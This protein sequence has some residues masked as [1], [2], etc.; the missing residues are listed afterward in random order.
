MTCLTWHAWMVPPGPPEVLEG[1]YCQLSCQRVHR[2]FKYSQE[3]L[4]WAL[5]PP[6]YRGDWILG[7][8]V[9][10]SGKLV[11][12]ITGVPATV[13]CTRNCC[14]HSAGGLC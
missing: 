14:M 11:A 1:S 4:Q 9:S 12:F 10:G 6:G 2:R 13:R 8:R 3:F 7:V 5:Q